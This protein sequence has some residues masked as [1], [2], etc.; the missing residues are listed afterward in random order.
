MNFSNHENDE[1]IAFREILHFCPMLDY[2]KIVTRT[3][4][5]NPCGKALDLHLMM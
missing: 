2:Y 3:N 5:E 1:K 4:F